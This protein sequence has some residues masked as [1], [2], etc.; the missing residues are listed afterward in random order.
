[1]LFIEGQFGT[2][3]DHSHIDLRYV[4][5]G[6]GFSGGLKMCEK[7]LGLNRGDLDGIDGYFA[8]LLWL[9]YQQNNNVR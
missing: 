1:M 5:K 9:D 6:L 4:L 7:A 8:I 3:I 2:T